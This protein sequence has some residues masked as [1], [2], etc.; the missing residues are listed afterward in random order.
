MNAQARKSLNQQ[1]Y[2]AA[3]KKSV[4]PDD[5]ELVRLMRSSAVRATTE[6]SRGKDMAIE[7]YKDLTA[8]ELTWAIRV[9]NQDES[10]LK[11]FA[12]NPIG[13]S[14][15]KATLKEQRKIRF[16]LLKIGVEYCTV[17][18]VY[19]GGF[20]GEELR[21]EMRR[22]FEITQLDGAFSDHVYKNWA[23]TTARKWLTEGQFKCK[24]FR[25]E[26]FINWADLTGDEAEYLIIRLTKMDNEVVQRKPVYPPVSVEFSKN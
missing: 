3:R 24:A 2:L 12:P 26:R 9:C 14:G 10:V 5:G 16:L 6:V 15:N 19:I 18:G 23:I 11:F 17:D 7:D 20:T 1:L 21:K 25:G 8:E 22:R 4:N 13:R